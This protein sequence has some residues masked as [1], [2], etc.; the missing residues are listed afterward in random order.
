[1]I[2]HRTHSNIMP[3]K[4]LH[5]SPIMVDIGLQAEGLVC[6]IRYLG[7]SNDPSRC[8]CRTKQI[9]MPPVILWYT[10]L[11]IVGWVGLLYA[12][13]VLGCPITWT[14]VLRCRRDTDWC[15]DI[16]ISASSELDFLQGWDNQWAN[17][18]SRPLRR[19][20]IS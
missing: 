4:K 10:D 11:V 5:S 7:F 20:I 9:A 18:S 19:P 2:D 13:S 12:F 6:A 17:R 8:G 14:T 1:M 16:G 3:L 15:I